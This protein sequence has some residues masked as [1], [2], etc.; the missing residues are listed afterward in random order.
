MT[1]DMLE[2]HAVSFLGFSI[3]QLCEISFQQF[4]TQP[5]VYM[6]KAV[7]LLYSDKPGSFIS[8]NITIGLT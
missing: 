4:L 5:E 7:N 3:E 6:N 1:D 8:M 2:C